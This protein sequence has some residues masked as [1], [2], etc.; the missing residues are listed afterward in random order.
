M[1]RLKSIG[2]LLIASLVQFSLV[3]KLE[4]F[5]VSAN[6]F[7]PI[8]IIFAIG[9]GE[10]RGAYTGMFFGLLEDIL[11]SK[12]IGPRALAYFLLGLLVGS[13]NYRLNIK[14]KRTGALITALATGLLVIVSLG[15]S[16]YMGM[17]F[18]GQLMVKIIS[19]ESILN[20]IL[21]YL[22]MKIFT[23]IFVF[24]DIVF[25]R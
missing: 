5:G 11:F 10:F 25:Y 16:A 22:L 15:I 14:D 19:I 4:V 7:I 6:I 1:N 3:S 23:R 2:V 20:F 21:Y 18:S 8:T 9:F 13:L 24:P 12:I 17:E